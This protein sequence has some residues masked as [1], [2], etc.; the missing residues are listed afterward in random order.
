MHT[1]ERLA[2][3]HVAGPQPLSM[4]QQLA[5]YRVALARSLASEELPVNLHQRWLEKAAAHSRL[6]F[7]AQRDS[8]LC[9]Q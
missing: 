4:S 6:L 1:A 2:L 3:L 7:A 8:A 9:H 5:W